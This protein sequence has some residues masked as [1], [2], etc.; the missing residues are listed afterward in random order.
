MYLRHEGAVHGSRPFK[1]LQQQQI[2][3]TPAHGAAQTKVIP[4]EESGKNQTWTDSSTRP[5]FQRRGFQCSTV[6]GVKD[7]RHSCLK[8]GI[9]R[10]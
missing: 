5:K 9:L 2:L 6:A 8:W 10:F 3:K 4:P 1:E 7:M